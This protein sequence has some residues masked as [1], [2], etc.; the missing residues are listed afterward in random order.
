MRL[1]HLPKAPRETVLLGALFCAALVLRTWALGW[2]L[3]YV[4][5]LDEP[6]LL[7]IAV[8]MVRD[9]DPNPHSFLYP[10]LYLYLIAA[11]IRVH[12]LLGMQQ[13]LYTALADLPLKHYQFTTTPLLFVWARAVTAL[14]GA[15]TVPALYVLGRHMFNVRTGLLAASVL[16]VA[17]FHTAHSHYLTTDA[18][19]GLWVV[20]ALLAAWSVSAS[21]RWRPYLLG[22][23]MVG[24]AAGTKYN[25]A[26]VALALP[27]AHFLFWRRQ[28]IGWPL[29]R[30]VA[31][32]AVAGLTFLAT[33]P[34]ALL[35][36]P[37]FLAGLRFNAEHYAAGL[38]GDFVGRWQIGEYSIFVWREALFPPACSLLVVGLPVLLRR[39]PRQSMLL[40]AAVGAALLL[41]LSY[42]VNFVR[43]L[44]PIFPLL[45]LL[46]AAATF[47]L[48][49]CV[50]APAL[51]RPL[52]ALLLV[53][54][55]VMPVRDT[56]WQLRYWSRPHTMQQA[57][58]QLRQLPQGMRTAV[59]LHPAQWS[60][61]PSVFPVD[62]LTAYGAD[63]YR[64]HGFRYLVA[65]D[66]LRSA[67]DRATY[68]QLKATARVIAEYPRRRAGIQPGPGG[69]LLDL[70]EHEEAIPFARRPMQFA[71]ELRLLGYELRPGPLRERITPLEGAD[72]HQ[73]AAGDPLQ[74]NLYWRAL[75]QLQADYTLFVHV[76]DANGQRVAQRDLPLRYSDYPTSKWQPGE[77]VIDRADLQLPALSAGSYQLM[78][79]V[80][81]AAA[82]TPPLSPGEADGLLTTI[83]IN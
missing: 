59:E 73:V 50:P 48:T 10:S 78:I 19:T 43:N 70:G 17:S 51:R 16:M 72:Q 14:L 66:D 22:G 35:D 47:A 39:Y 5:H 45:V 27:L 18:P 54:L 7:E 26:A 15:A 52:V 2:G 4:E 60:G 61:N 23:M 77:L 9:G 76:V 33:T 1:P 79:G 25:A 6:A 3:P 49:D 82:G 13:G 40:L 62:Q 8:R 69:A 64:A 36:Y 12:G 28:S 65:N 55:L 67:N 74:I 63:W 20:L 34:Y 29:G 11:A 46:S 31:G 71:A 81:D 53:T 58:E 83:A 75:R 21:G 80:Y 38:H 30:L 37:S 42:K 32:G 44:L 56:L 68:E 41:L 24:L 57:A